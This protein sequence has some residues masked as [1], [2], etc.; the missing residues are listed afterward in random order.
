[1]MNVVYDSMHR[2]VGYIL[3]YRC[4]FQIEYANL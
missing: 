3:D 1:M 4:I 2:I